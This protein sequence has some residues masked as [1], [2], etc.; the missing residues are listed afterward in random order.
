MKHD[1]SFNIHKNIPPPPPRGRPTRF[2][3]SAEEH[4]DESFCRVLSLPE[5]QKEEDGQE[6]NHHFIIFI[7]I[8]LYYGQECH[9][10]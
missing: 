10:A 3:S 8:H 2:A 5:E 4:R 6:V 7:P 1:N 9:S